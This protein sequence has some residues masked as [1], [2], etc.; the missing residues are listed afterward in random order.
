MRVK[1]ARSPAAVAWSRS[2]LLGGALSRTP[3]LLELPAHGEVALEVRGARVVREREHGV[4]EFAYVVF[5]LAHDR[6]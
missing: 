3:R 5:H 1:A 6:V 2:D 4:D